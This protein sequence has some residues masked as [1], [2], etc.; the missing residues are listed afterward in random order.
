MKN[1]ILYILS[2]LILLTLAIGCGPQKVAEETPVR[3]YPEDLSVNV[4][5]ES[6]EVVWKNDCNALI[7]GYN[8]YI[9]E[10][11]LV[12]K[13]SGTSLPETIEP[14]N[15]APYAGDTDPDDGIEHY[16]AD[17]L[18]NGKKYYVSVRIINPDRTLSK[19]TNE[20]EAVCGP[21]REIE[22]S[23]RLKS[24]QDGFSFDQNEYVRSN[25][26]PNDMYFFSKDGKDY[27]NSPVKLDGFLKNNKLAKL[28]VKGA[29]DQIRTQTAKISTVAGDD[30]VEIKKGDWLRLT[31]P[32]N[33]NA[34][35]NILDIYG[36]DEN[37]KIKLFIAYS[38]L[39]G[40]MLF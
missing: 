38:P 1:N 5:S 2:L 14:N 8:I 13:Y 40:S 15:T 31:T 9:N 28:S 27:L 17:R 25:A 16:Q 3:C 19:P 7:S 35:I 23:I 22:L 32:A 11:P 39:P 34:L 6:M 33:T 4:N 26:L 29:F 21:R 24:E 18:E 10:T 30:K 36:Q 12:E 37:R 20:I